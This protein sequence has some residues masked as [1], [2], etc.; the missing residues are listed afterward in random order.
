MKDLPQYPLRI[1]FMDEEGRPHLRHFTE[2]PLG[3]QFTSNAPI[4]VS[5][6][7]KNSPAGAD[8]IHKDNPDDTTLV[9][10]GDPEPYVKVGWYIIE[11]GDEEVNLNTNFKEVMNY[12][13][14]GVSLL[15][16]KD[17]QYKRLFC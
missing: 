5:Y 14:E 1:R 16:H 13:K 17:N 6:V 9:L 2:R 11:I 15:P 4:Q 7:E 10:E 8:A 3:I 12:I